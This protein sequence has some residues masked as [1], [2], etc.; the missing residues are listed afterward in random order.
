MA[1]KF[2]LIVKALHDSS[3]DAPKVKA[4]G[5]TMGHLTGFQ[6]LHKELKAGETRASQARKCMKG[7]S[8][9]KT[10]IMDPKLELVLQQVIANAV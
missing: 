1:E 2:T 8:R 5:R 3:E 9:S 4:G 7:L 6:A 10:L